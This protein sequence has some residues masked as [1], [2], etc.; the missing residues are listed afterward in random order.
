M[1]NSVIQGPNNAKISFENP[2]FIVV[3]H[4]DEC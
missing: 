1:V 2:K 3:L 4:T